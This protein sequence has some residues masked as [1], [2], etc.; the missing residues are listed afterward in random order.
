MAERETDDTQDGAARKFRV[1]MYVLERGVALEHALR[2]LDGVLE[3][4]EV[5]RPDDTGILEVTVTATSFDD[6]LTKVWDAVAAAGVDDQLAF[7]EHPNLPEHWRLRARSGP[8]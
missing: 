1:A 7:A 8:T 3:G 4:G 5:G 2:D 6:A